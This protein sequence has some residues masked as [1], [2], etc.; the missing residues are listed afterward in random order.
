MRLCVAVRV[1]LEDY[2]SQKWW[3]TLSGLPEHQNSMLVNLLGT[4]SILCKLAYVF[5]CCDSYCVVQKGCLTFEE[6]ID[7]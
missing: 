1:D 4:D 2:L 3:Q 6:R 5:N 7:F